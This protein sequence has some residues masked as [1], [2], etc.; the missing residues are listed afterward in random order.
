M[1][2]YVKKAKMEDQRIELRKKQL[3]KNAERMA[4]ARAKA[5]AASNATPAAASPAPLGTL[6]C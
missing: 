6:S 1:Q 5:L 2:D 3:A 4:Q